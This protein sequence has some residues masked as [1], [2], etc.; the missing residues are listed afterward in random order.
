MTCHAVL[1][2]LSSCAGA[3]ECIVSGPKGVVKVK[4]VVAKAGDKDEEH[5][6]QS[7]ELISVRFKPDKKS[8]T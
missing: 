2:P 5:Q 3:D 6:A 4:A 1:S 7:D 8:I